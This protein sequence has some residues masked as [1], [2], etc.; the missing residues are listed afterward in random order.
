MYSTPTL[1][2]CD[3]IRNVYLSDYDKAGCT[4]CIVCFLKRIVD[5]LSLTVSFSNLISS[6]GDS[7]AESREAHGAGC[8]KSSLNFKTDRHSS[9]NSS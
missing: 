3:L 6:L 9:V 4:R 1:R 5:L 7:S 2:R 8:F